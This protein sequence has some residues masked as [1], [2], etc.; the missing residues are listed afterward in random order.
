MQERDILQS[1]G[2]SR[3]AG[4]R[5]SKTIA[6]VLAAEKNAPSAARSTCA[7]QLANVV[8]TLRIEGLV[9]TAADQDFLGLVRGLGLSEQ[10]TV[11]IVA[12]YAQAKRDSK[13][14]ADAPAE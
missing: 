10:A 13:R 5:L 14:L 6:K 1:F 9:L 11:S 7:A 12:A 3:P 2:L 8:G 4:Q